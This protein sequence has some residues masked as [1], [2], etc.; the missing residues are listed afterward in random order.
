MATKGAALGIEVSLEDQKGKMI[1]KENF[2][3][4][5]SDW[6]KYS[7]ILKQN[8]TEYSGRLAMRIKNTGRLYLDHVS[9]FPKRPF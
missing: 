3:I 8:V 2:E 7:V 6:K 5:E 4:K 9:L 1:C